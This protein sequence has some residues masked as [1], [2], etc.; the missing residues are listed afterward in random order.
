MHRAEERWR[1][2]AAQ[3]AAW[4]AEDTGRPPRPDMAA[5]MMTTQAA[6]DL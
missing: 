6:E 2:V 1:P 3:Q 5:T 4:E